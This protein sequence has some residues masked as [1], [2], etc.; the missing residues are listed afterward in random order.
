MIATISSPRTTWK[1]EPNGAKQ[2][3]PSG[4]SATLFS[5]LRRRFQAV[6]MVMH[7]PI[8]SSLDTTAVSLLNTLWDFGPLVSFF[9][10]C[11]DTAA[12]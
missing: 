6:V 10:V 4:L 7:T 3:V 5:Y 1:V 12:A 11:H 2:G 9:S 8:H